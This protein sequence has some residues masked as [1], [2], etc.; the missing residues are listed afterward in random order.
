MDAD[1]YLGPGQ[2]SALGMVIFVKRYFNWSAQECD[3]AYRIG[4]VFTIDAGYY[5][6]LDKRRHL[7][8][9]ACLMIITAPQ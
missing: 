3:H 9:Y 2:K 4:L 5:L 8:T 7:G 6:E 1:H